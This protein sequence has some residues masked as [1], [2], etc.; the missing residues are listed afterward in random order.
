M[1]HGDEPKAYYL[2]SPFLRVFHWVMFI[3]TAILLITGLYIGHPFFFCSRG[4]DPTSAVQALLSM[5]GIRYIHFIAG[6][7]LLASFIFRVYGLMINR[8]DRLWPKFR[9]KAYLE[10]LKDVARYYLFITSTHRPY[11]R[12]SLARTTYVGLYGMM[13]VMIITGFT[14]YYQINP[15]SRGAKLL[16]WVIS[17]VGGEYPVHVI[18]HVVAWFIVLFVIIHVYMVIRADVIEK[19]GE[20]SSMFSGMKYMHKPTDIEDI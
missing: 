3:T 14:M 17:L 19:E 12:N 11:L 9:Q 18:H 16:G 1:R 15:H 6:W 10:G 20:I 13:A 5:E 7:I 8:G 4:I 2:F